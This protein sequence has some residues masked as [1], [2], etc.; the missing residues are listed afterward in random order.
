IQHESSQPI[1][2][3]SQSNPLNA[4]KT[5]LNYMLFKKGVATGQGLESGA[6]IKSRPDLENPDL[7]FHFI[8]ALM[9]DHT[10]K[11]PDRHGFMAHVC[12]LRPQSRGYI[13]IKSADPLVAP[14]IQPNYLEAEEDRRAM[15]E[16][17]KIAR[18]IFAQ[19]SFDPYRGPELMPGAHVRSD[20]QIDT[21][22]R[23]TAETIYHP[24]GSAKMGKDSES[25]VDAQLRVYGVEGLRVIDASVMPTLVSG[26]TNAPTIMIAEKAADMILGRAPL[27]PEH[28]QVAE[29]RATA[30]E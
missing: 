7:Q 20:E 22:V 29:D 13:S 2:L 23:R 18:E 14:V 9:S 5:G 6:F 3:Y 15:R 1:T 28:V 12:Q 26:N 25:V 10:R 17:T 27:P 21:W 19:A 4:M 11:K 8:A 30:A 16:G 24:V